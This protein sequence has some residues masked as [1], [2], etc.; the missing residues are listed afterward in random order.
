MTQDKF[1]Y[2]SLGIGF[3]IVA[4][5]FFYEDYSQLFVSDPASNT[6]I[7]RQVDEST[8]TDTA[9][10]QPPTETPTTQPVEDDSVYR[11]KEGDTA[12]SIAAEF[13]LDIKDLVAM[14]PTK[15]INTGTKTAEGKPIYIIH[16]G[17]VLKIKE[18]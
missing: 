11:V 5:I 3:F 12:Y 13:N 4:I 17:E 18:G 7:P 14:N 16:A 15:I 9:P 8:G 10:L 2:V 6:E 1:L